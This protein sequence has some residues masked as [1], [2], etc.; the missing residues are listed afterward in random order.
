MNRKRVLTALIAALLFA[1][2]AM[3]VDVRDFHTAGETDWG[4]AIQSAID[5]L[6]DTDPRWPDESGGEIR[7]SKGRHVVTTPILMRCPGVIISGEGSPYSHACTIEW[8][9]KDSAGAL[10]TFVAPP[11][12]GNRSNGFRMRDIKLYGNKSG[13]AFRF[14][15]K[16]R[17]SRDFVFERVSVSYFAKVFEFQKGPS[18]AWGGLVCN[19]CTL[20]YNGQVLDATAGGANEWRFEDCL[21]SKNGLGSEGWSPTYAFDF[22][23]GDNGVFEGCILEGQPRALRVRK[24]QQLRI[25]GCRFEGNATSEDPV[26]LVE[27]SNGVYI[28]AYHR[29]LGS[30]Q[31][32][33]A[34]PTILLRRCRDYE[35]S[36]QL[37]KVH[38]ERR[39]EPRF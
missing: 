4:P 13:V 12:S 26:V 36:P 37:G 38:I 5:S 33:E 14:A 8:R 21:L 15:A 31:T 34:P 11:A 16:A 2:I 1:S 6:K 20:V 9:G 29:V 22:R 19:T 23:G 27:D 25:T 30:E 10:F 7:F 32:A 17:Y 18:H 28:Q 39:W 24:F 35:V 3:A